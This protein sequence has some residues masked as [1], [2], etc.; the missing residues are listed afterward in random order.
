M[1]VMSV[2]AASVL[3]LATNSG[4]CIPAGNLLKSIEI[5]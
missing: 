1:I 2:P 5:Y 4:N 3:G